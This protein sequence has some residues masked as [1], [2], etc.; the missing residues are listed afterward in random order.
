MF[1]LALKEWK[2]CNIYVCDCFNGS[3][4]EFNKKL[5]FFVEYVVNDSK[6]YV[7]CGFNS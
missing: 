2:K 1:L 7:F 6:N 3:F 5:V 4:W